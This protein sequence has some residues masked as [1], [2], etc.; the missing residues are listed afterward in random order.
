MW[1]LVV[2]LLNSK[3]RTHRIESRSPPLV[4][5]M[6]SISKLVCHLRNKTSTWNHGTLTKLPTPRWDETYLSVNRNLSNFYIN[7]HMVYLLLVWI[8][9]WILKNDTTNLTR[10]RPTE[11]KLRWTTT[12]QFGLTSRTERLNRRLSSSVSLDL[13]YCVRDLNPFWS[14]SEVFLQEICHTKIRSFTVC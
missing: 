10:L 2:L 1:N 7:I 9:K 11:E 14:E 8:R 6:L 12:K 5:F 3:R 13:L 4:P